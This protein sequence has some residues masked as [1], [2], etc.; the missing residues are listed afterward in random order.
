[1]RNELTAWSCLTEVRKVSAVWGSTPTGLGHFDTALLM[2]AGRTLERQ[3]RGQ[4]EYW[5]LDLGTYFGHSAFSIV[6]G[7]AI[8][9]R[10]PKIK[11]LSIDVFQ[12][13]DWLLKESSAAIAFVKEFGS[14]EPEG[15]GNWL[16]LACN[17]IGLP[18]NPISLMK[19]DV[20]TLSPDDLV[21]V[22]PRGYDLITVDCGKTPELM[23]RI[24]EFLTCREVCGDRTIVL[25]QD[26]FDWHAPWNAFALWKLLETGVLSLHYAGP[27]ATPCAEKVADKQ[28]GPICDG[29]GPARISGEAWSIPFTSFEREITALEYWLDIFRAWRCPDFALRIECLRAG[30]LLRDGQIDAAERHISRLDRDWPSAIR[31]A[32]LQTIYCRLLHMKTGRKD[33][34]LVFDT[35]RHRV[36]NSL[37]AKMLQAA[38]R[39]LDY[40]SPVI[41]ETDCTAVE[42]KAEYP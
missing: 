11:V 9:N 18:Y 39:R 40:L 5:T 22:A 8:A 24:V 19:R 12:Q 32:Y 27:H 25:F 35:P 36:R 7:A 42:R 17:R 4:G 13:P 38:S 30:A 15:I 23:N 6:Y 1:V 20:L 3:R 33:L 34:S 29:I 16:S 28:I 10:A 41:L 21:Y 2:L 26:L 37:W 14:T 31:D